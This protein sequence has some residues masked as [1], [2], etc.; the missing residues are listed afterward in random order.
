MLK[1]IQ[2]IYLSIENKSDKTYRFSRQS[3]SIKTLT[4]EEAAKKGQRNTFTRMTIPLMISFFILWP[5]AIWAIGDGAASST[6]N[7]QLRADYESK[8]FEEGPIRPLQ[9]KYGII[10]APNLGSGQDLNISL[11]EIETIEK[12]TFEFA[13]VGPD[14]FKPLKPPAGGTVDET[15]ATFDPKKPWAGTWKV[16][17]NFYYP[18]GTWVLNQQEEKV[19]SD[20]SSGF[21]MK[22]NIKT[23]KVKG[24]CGSSGPSYPCE[25][26]LSRDGLSF[27]GSIDAY[28]THK[29]HG[30][31][32]GTRVKTILM[33]VDYNPEEPW[34]GKWEVQYYY[35]GGHIFSLK[36]DSNEVISTDDSCCKMEGKIEGAYLKGWV[37]I[38]NQRGQVRLKIS[39]DSTTFKGTLR[40]SDWAP[41]R[42][43][44]FGKRQEYMIIYN[45]K[46]TTFT[47][48][49]LMIFRM[50]KNALVFVNRPNE[51]LFAKTRGRK[52]K[53]LNT[54]RTIDAT[55]C[56][57]SR[58]HGECLQ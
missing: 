27:E 21:F 19:R 4:H 47:F 36:Q 13:N 12:L 15:I 26:K 34:T 30:K 8:A 10:Y 53:G 5:L 50:N 9:Y 29:F 11:A 56:L 49:K 43:Y 22:G 38:Q 35:G 32:Q 3:L 37:V 45:N 57:S 31:R 44:I 48:C 6:A 55:R 24:W 39:S 25:L 16:D 2:P 28:G 58:Y 23:T 18:R 46:K 51:N 7:K 54:K 20:K 1:G 14:Y 41:D 42:D 40:G 17:S 33:P 52:R